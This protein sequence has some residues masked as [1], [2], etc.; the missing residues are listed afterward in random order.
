MGSNVVPVGM[1]AEALGV[2]RQRFLLSLANLSRCQLF[3]LLYR[4]SIADHVSGREKGVQE[5]A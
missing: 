5:I 3:R 4:I 2:E 1:E